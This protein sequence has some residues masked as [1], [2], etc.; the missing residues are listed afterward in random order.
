[1]RQSP[2]KPGSF[3]M[4][5]LL[6]GTMICEEKD[7]IAGIRVKIRSVSDYY[8]N[9][10]VNELFERNAGGTVDIYASNE[11]FIKGKISL[12]D[13][14]LSIIGDFEVPWK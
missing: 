11:Q 7:K 2:I 6:P 4:G 8:G 12:A 5:Q 14:K 1:M 9:E 10:V 13:A 3:P